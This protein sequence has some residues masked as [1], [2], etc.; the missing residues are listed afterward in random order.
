MPPETAFEKTCAAS[1]W[2]VSAVTASHGAPWSRWYE[3]AT[4]RRSHDEFSFTPPVNAN[5]ATRNAATASDH[6]DFA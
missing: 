2:S 1:A 4:P 6:V 5:I 3:S